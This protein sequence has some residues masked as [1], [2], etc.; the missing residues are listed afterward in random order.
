M[1]V[2]ISYIWQKF[3]LLDFEIVCLLPDGRRNI[4][5]GGMTVVELFS[6]STCEASPPVTSRFAPRPVR[7]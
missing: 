6:K 2:E 1:G 7:P 5:S 4:D 3:L